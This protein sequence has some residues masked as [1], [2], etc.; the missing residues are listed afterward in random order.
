VCNNEY[1]E[2]HR[3]AITLSNVQCFSAIFSVELL[4]ELDITLT[5]WVVLHCVVLH[6]VVCRVFLSCV[7]LCCDLS[8]IC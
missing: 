7:V 3:L 2:L 6:F 1:V 4:V 5:G 8:L